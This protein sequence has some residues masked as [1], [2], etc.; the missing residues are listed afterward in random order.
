M[1]TYLI[2]WNHP[3]KGRVTE[4][5][6]KE[7]EQEVLGALQTLGIGCTGTYGKIDICFRCIYSGYRFRDWMDKLDLE[8]GI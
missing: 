2:Q 7:H 5:V 3:I 1:T 6:C 4:E 8:P